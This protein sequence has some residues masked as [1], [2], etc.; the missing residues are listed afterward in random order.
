[1]GLTILK[2][3]KGDRVDEIFCS[4][5]APHYFSIAYFEAAVQPLGARA[6]TKL[7]RAK[8]SRNSTTFAGLRTITCLLSPVRFPCETGKEDRRAH[9]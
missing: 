4:L 2:L 5:Y 1:M 8:L 3:R 9:V 6:F 7:R